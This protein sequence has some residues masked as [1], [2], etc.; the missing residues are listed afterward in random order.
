M[1]NPKPKA[2]RKR[3]TKVK[4]KIIEEIAE[5][6]ESSDSPPPP[7]GNP[8]VEFA[9]L[10]AKGI[11]RWYVFLAIPFYAILAHVLYS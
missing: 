1:K 2:P 3:R 5:T 4:I 6:R 9:K 7:A 8:H 10:A 11:L